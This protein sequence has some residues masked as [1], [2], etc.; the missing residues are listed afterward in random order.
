MTKN[1]NIINR[2]GKLKMMAKRGE[3][4]ERIVAKKK[5]KELYLKY[6]FNKNKLSEKSSRKKRILKMENWTDYLDISIHCIYSIRPN[7]KIRGNENLKQVIVYLTQYEYQQFKKQFNRYWNLYLKERHAFLCAF[8]IKNNLGITIENNSTETLDEKTL[9][10]INYLEIIKV[11]N[12]NLKRIE[13][14]N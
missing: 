2:I 5:L 7:I 9:S 11:A 4:N 13:Q 10:I 6:D 3:P 14:H 8:L 12:I 1:K